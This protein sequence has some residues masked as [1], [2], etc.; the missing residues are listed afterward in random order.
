M[1]ELPEVETVKNALAPWL[2]GRTIRWARRVDAPDGPKYAGLE[3]AQGQAIVAVER[4]GKFIVLP[5]SSGDEMVVHLGMTGVLSPEPQVDHVRVEV[6]LEG[7]GPNRLYFRDPRRFGRFVVLA[8]GGRVALPTLAAM[9]PEP[10]SDA[11]TVSG[12]FAALET[13]RSALKAVLLGQRVVA[14]VGNIYA[15]EAL[16][17]AGL[18]PE[19]RADRVTKRQAAVLHRVI[20][21]VLAEAIA[22]GG[23]T[24]RDY[25]QLD[26]G[27]GTHQEALG[28]YGRAGG[29]CARCESVLERLVVAQRGTTFCP[30]CQR[31][32]RA[33]RRAK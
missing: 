9:G 32:G 16:W 6:A 14:G 3:R 12:L 33:G 29:A 20:R 23:T 24:L 19:L 1:P 18:H 15:D 22:H 13:K 26:G 17:R 4:R 5:L 21:E 10:L 30:V 2:A 11:F 25:R 27:S 7:R 8:P 31:R 28:V